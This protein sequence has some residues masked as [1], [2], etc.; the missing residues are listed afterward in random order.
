MTLRDVVDIYDIERDRASEF[1]EIPEL[2]AGLKFWA[3]R[4]LAHSQ[5]R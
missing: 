5:N 1:L 4:R 3:Q 2:A